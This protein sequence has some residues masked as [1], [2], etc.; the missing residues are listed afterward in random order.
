MRAK[1]IARKERAAREMGSAAG[2]LVRRRRWITAGMVLLWVAAVIA[3]HVPQEDLPKL[4]LN[5]KIFHV[6][7]FMALAGMFSLVLASRGWK[8]VKRDLVVLLVMSAYAAFDEF[9]QNYFHR[10]GQV[11]DWLLDTASAAT[12]LIICRVLAAPVS[13]L[14]RRFRLARLMRQKNERYLYP[15]E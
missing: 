10:H 14:I 11:S 6:L 5:F 8:G 1:A 7:G 15:N 9:T 12:V 2:T 13:A 3:S 4:P